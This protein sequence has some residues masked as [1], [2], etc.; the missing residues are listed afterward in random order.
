MFSVSVVPRSLV[1]RRRCQDRSEP[2][3]G[4]LVM[5]IGLIN[6]WNRLNILTGQEAGSLTG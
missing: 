4:G 6:L 3:L 1:S 2:A 5:T